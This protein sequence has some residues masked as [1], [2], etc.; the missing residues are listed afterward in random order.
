[1]PAKALALLGWLRARAARSSSGSHTHGSDFCPA[2]CH[3]E[4][5]GGRGI[6]HAG[7]R[8]VHLRAARSKQPGHWRHQWQQ[9]FCEC[10]PSGGRCVTCHAAWAAVCAVVARPACRRCGPDHT[11]LADED[12]TSWL[13][14]K[15]NCALNSA[16]HAFYDNLG[17]LPT[18]RM[19][20]RRYAD[21]PLVTTQKLAKSLRST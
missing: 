17:T 21:T 14:V 1:M 6:K 12:H 4:P 9:K 11:S 7:R 10:C 16:D 18:I 8:C 2:P 13:E 19:T 20:R 3:M 5:E 15:T